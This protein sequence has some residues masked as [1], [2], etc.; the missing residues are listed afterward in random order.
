VL[1][2]TWLARGM[3]FF[4]GVALVAILL[5]YEH[6]LVGRGNLAKIDRVFFDINGYVSCG[7]FALT[8]L[9]KWLA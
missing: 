3:A 6:A 2:G 4:A 7:F 5:G 1:T 9:D 8:L